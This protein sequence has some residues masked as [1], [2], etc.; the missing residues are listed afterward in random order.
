MQKLTYFG[1]LLLY[2]YEYD[3]FENGIVKN[4]LS[5]AIKVALLI[6]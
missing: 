6:V 3:I 4:H 1:G 5:V 2:F